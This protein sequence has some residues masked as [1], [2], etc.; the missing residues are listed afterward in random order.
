MTTRNPAA[1]PLVKPV[2]AALDMSNA[3]MSAMLTLVDEYAAT[4]I[5]K[6]GGEAAAD[7]A[8][9]WAAAGVLSIEVTHRAWNAAEA[10]R[11]AAGAAQLLVR[12]VDHARAVRL[13][14]GLQPSAAKRD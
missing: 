10:S 9:I 8:R 5:S 11:Y 13:W 14:D 7:A 3:L 6:G 2:G 12:A 4:F 1:A